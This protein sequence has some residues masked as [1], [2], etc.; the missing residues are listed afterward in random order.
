MGE[1]QEAENKEAQEQ[2]KRSV[3][4]RFREELKALGV[5]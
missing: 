1:N 2:G 3:W 4:K 5:F